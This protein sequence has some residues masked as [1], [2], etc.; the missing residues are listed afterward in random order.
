MRVPKHQW[1]ELHHAHKAGQIQNFGVGVPPVEHAGEVEELCALVDFGPEA[2]LEAFF[3]LALD[4]Y[5]GY[6]VE[7][8]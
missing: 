2:L 8:G 7:M 1:A 5:F 4:C 3:G 6:E